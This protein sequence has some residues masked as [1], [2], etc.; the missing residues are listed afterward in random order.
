MLPIYPKIESRFLVVQEVG[1]SLVVYDRSRAQAHH[2]DAL[3]TA[4]WGL[5]D[6][7]RELAT[8]ADRLSDDLGKPVL[9]DTVSDIVHRF[10]DLGLLQREE[11]ETIDRREFVQRAGLAAA[12]VPFITSLSILRPA[13]AAS[14]NCTV[15][16]L[17]DCCPCTSNGSCD[18]GCCATPLDGCVPP[19]SLMVGAPCRAS[20][21]C[22]S[23]ICGFGFLCAMAGSVPSGENC[24]VNGECMSG[25]C[26]T[27]PG[28]APDVCA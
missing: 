7:S 8:I 16:P 9:D 6:G 24:R 28:S 5:C 1:D 17:D 22:S 10:F 20:C 14:G 4:V 27:V 15:T 18:S 2:F 3:A 12:A 13:S 11:V 19:G 23:D 26:V 21:S 25:N